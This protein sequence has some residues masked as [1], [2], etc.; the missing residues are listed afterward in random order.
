MYILHTFGS[1]KKKKKKHYTTLFG[2]NWGIFMKYFKM[3]IQSVYETLTVV[4]IFE[5]TSQSSSRTFC[6]FIPIRICVHI[7]ILHKKL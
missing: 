3:W 6:E 5:F 4:S 2:E 7:K 1:L